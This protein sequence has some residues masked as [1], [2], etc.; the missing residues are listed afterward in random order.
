VTTKALSTT[1]PGTIPPTTPTGLTPIITTPTSIFHSWNPSTD[2]GG[3]GLAGYRLY[4]NGA[5]IA[6]LP[7]T[8]Y[9][10]SGLA[11]K[12]AY[13]YSVSAYDQAG[14]G[15]AV[16]TLTTAGI[17]VTVHVTGKAGQNLAGATVVLDGQSHKTDS[18]G[19]ASFTNVPPGHQAVK[20]SYGISTTKSSLDVGK[21]AANGKVPIN[22]NF[23]LVAANSTLSEQNLLELIGLL[24]L[25][26]VGVAWR[27]RI[28]P[29]RLWVHPVPQ[30]VA[31]SQSM[32]APNDL[33]AAPG[34]AE[35]P[36][37]PANPSLSVSDDGMPLSPPMPGSRI[38]PQ[39]Q[40]DKP[41]DAS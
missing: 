31:G 24:I 28:W 40:A 32:A 14:S 25:L 23:T 30:P 21:P 33:P 15:S 22:Q 10:D 8:T 7:G 35:D 16:S 41:E 17:A 19:D 37:Q 20:I 2:T 1:S 6:S 34:P 27:Y 4:R 38:E 5:L 9:S 39:G 11:P 18:Q 13:T 26:A 36:L 29:M 3:R 12:T